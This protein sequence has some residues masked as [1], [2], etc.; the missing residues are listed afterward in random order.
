[1]RH[2]H[3]HLRQAVWGKQPLCRGVGVA[4][5]YHIK[6]SFSTSSSSSNS[7]PTSLSS[8][9]PF[10]L[11]ES[12]A[13]ECFKKWA[14]ELRFAPLEWKTNLVSNK[15]P[16]ERYFLPYWH[17]WVSGRVFFEGRIGKYRYVYE[18]NAATRRNETVRKTDWRYVSREFDFS[19]YST[20]YAGDMFERVY[21]KQ[22]IQ[23]IQFQKVDSFS[24]PVS[25]QDNVETYLIDRD[26]SWK[27]S[28]RDHV[29][30]SIR[31]D[32]LHILENSGY[33][34]DE[35]EVDSFVFHIFQHSEKII[36]F[37]FYVFKYGYLDTDFTI[38][39]NGRTGL[40]KGDRQYDF[41]TTTL[42][43]WGVG[44]T[45]LSVIQYLS[46]GEFL[47]YTPTSS[48]ILQSISWA[49][50]PSV[51]IGLWFKYYPWFLLRT[52]KWKKENSGSFNFSSGSYTYTFHEKEDAQR[53]YQ[54]Q[55][56]YQQQD[57]KQQQQQRQQS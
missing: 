14:K 50:V 24:V 35:Y 57:F 38:M 15:A 9:Q 26:T 13:E 4:Y 7:K 21:T 18:Y 10:S 30:P 39:I 49:F 42:L 20:S 23:N 32:S 46:H 54:Q 29:L 6:R 8:A 28:W 37:P 11:S 1:M 34:A 43:S 25:E 51:L 55:R 53:F 16:L 56:Q 48:L 12:E 52:R 2:P 22:L 44:S 47:Q 41:V 5:H 3:Q 17:F 27:I 40:V 19:T 36:Y 45:A 31:N 33:M